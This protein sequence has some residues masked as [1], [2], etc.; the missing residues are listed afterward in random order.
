MPLPRTALMRSGSWASGNGSLPASQSRCGRG[1][2]EDFHRVLPDFSAKYNVGSSYCVRRYIVDQHLGGPEGLA[3]AKR[4]LDDRGLR[5]ILDFV[6]N[7][8]APDH[9]WVTFH[10][11]NELGHWGC[12]VR[13]P[14]AKLT[15]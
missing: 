9:P 13:I 1:P 15:G 14:C 4:M 7:H 10:G 12:L 11:P 8:V 5:L 3:V 2:L 6:L